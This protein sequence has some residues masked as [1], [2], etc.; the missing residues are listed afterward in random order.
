MVTVEAKRMPT[1]MLAPVA[2]PH[3]AVGMMSSKHV[4]DPVSLYRNYRYIEN[5]DRQE[6]I[7]IY[8]N[9]LRLDGRGAGATLADKP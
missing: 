6:R 1:V 7:S 9:M 2:T 4:L 3:A 5:G 8:L